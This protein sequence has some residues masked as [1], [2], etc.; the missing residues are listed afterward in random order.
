MWMVH[1]SVSGPNGEAQMFI[2]AYKN[3]VI[4]DGTPYFDS[5]NQTHNGNILS[6]WTS[7]PS[8]SA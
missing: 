1:L 5:R 8:V 6:S 2:A 4:L 7:Q 3:G